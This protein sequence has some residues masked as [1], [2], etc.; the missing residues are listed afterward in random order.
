[1]EADHGPDALAHGMMGFQWSVSST[2]ISL[3]MC[4]LWLGVAPALHEP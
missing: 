3:K 2:A 4:D 1:M